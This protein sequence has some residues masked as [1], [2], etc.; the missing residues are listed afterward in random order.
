MVMTDTMTNE[1]ADLKAK[2]DALES[3]LDEKSGEIQDLE[4]A[5]YNL[6]EDKS[7]LESRVDDLNVE[8][9]EY[10]VR[11]DRLLCEKRYG[12]ATQEIRDG[13]LAFKRNPWPFSYDLHHPGQDAL[14]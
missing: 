5:L 9:V 11:A 4:S 10:L 7:A 6:G 14:L 12:E 8:A 3:E 13:L 1:V 2:I